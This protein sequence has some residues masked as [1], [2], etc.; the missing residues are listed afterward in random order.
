MN[1]TTVRAIMS[2]RTGDELTINGRVWFRIESSEF[3]VH[4]AGTEPDAPDSDTLFVERS[5]E[6]VEDLLRAFAEG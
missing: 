2:L 6:E 5:Q 4:K 3:K 1:T